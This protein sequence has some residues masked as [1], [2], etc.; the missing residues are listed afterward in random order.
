LI[1]I[2]QQSLRKETLA[3]QESLAVAS[4]DTVQKYVI[5]FR[6]VLTETGGPRTTSSR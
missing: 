3:M 2:S 1:N 4:P 5:T 6:N